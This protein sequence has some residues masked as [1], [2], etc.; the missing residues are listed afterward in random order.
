MTLIAGGVIQ[1]RFA[2]Y[3]LE[4]IDEDDVQQFIEDMVREALS[5]NQALDNAVQSIEL[6]QLNVERNL[7]V[8]EI[9]IDVTSRV[10]VSYDP[11]E[12]D[13][14]SWAQDNAEALVQQAVDNGDYSVNVEDEDTGHPDFAD[15]DATD[16]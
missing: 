1:V 6:T 8:A 2:D 16:L 13:I 14:Q 3:E 12:V 10:T 11:D 7:K 9:S 4:G 15:M 5:T